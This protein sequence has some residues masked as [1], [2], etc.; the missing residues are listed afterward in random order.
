MTQT[1]NLLVLPE[2]A[3]QES[4]LL[5]YIAVQIGVKAS[6]ING[7]RIERQSIDARSRIVKIQLQVLVFIDDTFKKVS[8]TKM[9]LFLI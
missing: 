6:R 1:L 8:A 7:F 4:I 5:K 9:R 3:T 2:E